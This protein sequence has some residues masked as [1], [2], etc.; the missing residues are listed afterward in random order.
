MKRPENDLPVMSRRHFGALAGSAAA[1][2]LLLSQP[3]RSHAL[4]AGAAT[5]LGGGVAANPQD[6]HVF[7]WRLYP[8][9][10]LLAV[11]TEAGEIFAHQLRDGQE[12]SAPWRAGELPLDSGVRWILQDPSYGLYVVRKN[13]EVTFH[14][15]LS[16]IGRFSAPG[17]TKFLEG[18]RVKVPTPV[19]VSPEDRRALTLADRV[20]VLR[21][22][23]ATGFHRIKSPNE[24]TAGAAT[25]PDSHVPVATNPADRWIIP[26]C[27]SRIGVITSAGE[28]FTHP[29]DTVSNRVGPPARANTPQ[30]IAANPQD[31]FVVTTRDEILVTTN[32]GDLYEHKISWCGV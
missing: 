22:D 29:Y 3:A 10:R 9:E 17:Q 11:I 5:K 16:S 12:I 2:T 24:W 7:A 1:A 30:P 31:R 19:G 32:T 8:N 27:N 23:G 4:D 25:A 6:R 15:M 13:G 14:Q 28:L 21:S 26:V 18:E 20:I